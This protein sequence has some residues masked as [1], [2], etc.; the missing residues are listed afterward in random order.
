MICTRC[1]TREAAP[2]FRRCDACRAFESK[3][4]AAYYER[5]KEARQ[6]YMRAWMAARAKAQREIAREEAE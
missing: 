4:S 3:R 2:G 1:T 5:C 6:A